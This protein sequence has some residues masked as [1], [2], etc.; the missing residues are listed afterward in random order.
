MANAVYPDFL[1]LLWNAGVNIGADTFRIA[2][3]TSG[4]VY[5]SAHQFF[6]SLTGV[7]ATAALTTLA[8]SGG[9]LS[10]DDTP[11]SGP[12][13]G[14]VHA[15]VVY[16]DTGVAGTS[17]LFLYLDTGVGFNV[18]PSGDL[19]VVWSKDS[20]ARIFPLGGRP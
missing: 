17:P 2:L 20:T 14:S 9:V 16:K 3:V 5:S 12:I 8:S 15:V 19:T 18:T 13:S 4:Y 11:V 1:D 7:L 6:S 10:A